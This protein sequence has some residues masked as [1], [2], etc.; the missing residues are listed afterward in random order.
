MR[1]PVTTHGYRLSHFLRISVIDTSQSD[2]N[3][4]L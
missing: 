2:L 4:C 1:E 3:F